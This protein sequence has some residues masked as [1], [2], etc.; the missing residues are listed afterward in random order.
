M[1]TS[2]DMTG[3]PKRTLLSLLGDWTGIT[4]PGVWNGGDRAFFFLTRL[5]AV[6]VVLITTLLVVELFQGSSEAIS[7]FGLGF[8]IGTT[9]DPVREEFGT[10][11]TIIG[12]VARAIIALL[13]AVPISIGAA[14]FIAYYAPRRLASAL[15][16][17][18]ES[19]ASIPSVIFGLWGLFVLVPIVRSFQIWLKANFGWFPLF[20]GPAAYGVGLLAGGLVLAIMITPIMASISRDILRTVPKSQTE[21]LLALGATKW[22]AIWKV[23]LP[24]ARGGLVGA[25]ILG[26][27]R[28]LGETMAVTMVGGNGFS[29]ATSL[30]DPVHSMASQIAAEFSEATYSLYISSLI[31]VG[32][33]LF[34][35]TIIVN[36]LA[37]W[38]I[39]R[40]SGTI[41]RGTE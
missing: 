8:L 15:S 10:F 40:T 37:Q 9:W 39:W 11:P 21:A 3:P 12:T 38:L 41:G 18:I 23:A 20:D 2:S 36:V 30:F 24:Y 5:A 16:Y 25:T 32:L 14:I 34:G 26:L 33:V 13:L 29:L 22:E 28:A 27:G 19:L 6:S 7:K 31:Y 17:M 4:P 35:I 1:A